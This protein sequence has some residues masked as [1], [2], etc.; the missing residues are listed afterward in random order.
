MSATL[1]TNFDLS[2]VTFAPFKAD[3]GGHGKAAWMNYKGGE[4]KFEGPRMYVPFPVQAPMEKLAPEPFTKMNLTL[5][6]NDQTDDGKIFL[7]KL[8]ELE[9]KTVEYS[10]ERLAKDNIIP[11]EQRRYIDTPNNLRAMFHPFIK[12]GDKKE[13]GSSHNPTFN[14]KISDIVHLVEKYNL[15]DKDDGKGNMKKVVGSVD[16]KEV[17]ITTPL[18]ERQPR[19]YMCHGKNEKGQPIVSKS[20]LV[21]DEDKVTKEKTVRMENGVPM[22]RWVGPQDIKK[23]CFVVPV[24]KLFKAH[25]VNKFGMQLVLQAVFIEPSTHSQPNMDL[26]NIQEMDDDFDSLVKANILSTSTLAPIPNL[27]SQEHQD[28]TSVQDNTSVQDMV[29]DTKINIPTD[30]PTKTRKRKLDN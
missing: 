27:E 24:F 28:T 3:P 13:D 26:N 8:E 6:I 20:V 15:V 18:H 12:A 14:L 22:K 4:N 16:W 19:F 5:S 29:Q 2:K 25:Y 23:G 30:L 11:S 7:D 1:F 9:N 10:F 17:S 21:Y